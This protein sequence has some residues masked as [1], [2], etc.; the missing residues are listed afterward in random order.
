MKR[1]ASLTLR[2]LLACLYA[3]AAV[4]LMLPDIWMDAEAQRLERK[5]PPIVQ[6]P[7][8]PELRAEIKALLAQRPELMEDDMGEVLR[9]ILRHVGLSRDVAGVVRLLTEPRR[10]PSG[11]LNYVLAGL[12]AG[13]AGFGYCIYVSEERDMAVN[14]LPQHASA[15]RSLDEVDFLLLY[16]NTPEG[17]RSVSVICRDKDRKPQP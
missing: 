13:K 5:T 3:C 7:L 2:L 17:L 10:T 4:Q 9:P 1:S 15:P 8:S 16:E 12:R 11:R 14:L 6:K